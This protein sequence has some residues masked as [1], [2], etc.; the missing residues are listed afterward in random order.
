MPT[1]DYV[2]KSCGHEFEHFQSMTGSPLK[3]CPKCARKSLK[4]LIGTGAGVIFK[5]E[6]FYTT[7]YRSESYKKAAE[8]EKSAS[9]PDAPKPEAAMSEAT[10]AASEGSASTPAA[11]TPKSSAPA[12]KIDRKPDRPRSRK[13]AG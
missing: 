8:S 5:G 3:T 11:E 12:E 6:G 2:C 13:K 7:D 1:Y 9:K 4:R 10:R